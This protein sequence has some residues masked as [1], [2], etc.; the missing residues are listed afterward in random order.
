MNEPP[1]RIESNGVYAR[2]DV[3]RYTSPTAIQAQAV[4]AG[5]GGRDVIGIAKTGSGKTAAF[6][7]P[8]VSHIM[9]QP[10]LEKGD[11]P[12]GEW[13]CMHTGPS[14]WLCARERAR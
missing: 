8:M 12:I 7:W 3:I 14:T 1:D 5:L 4:P 6:V 13:L 9:D 11:G 10:E 2:D